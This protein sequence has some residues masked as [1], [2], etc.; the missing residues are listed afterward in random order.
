MADAGIL[1]AQDRVAALY[2]AHREAIYRFLLT[3]GLEPATAQELA[4]DAFVHL[5]VSLSNGAMIESE[6][7]W[8]YSVAAKRAVDHWRREGRRISAP[9]DDVPEI[10]RS[11]KSNE[12]TPEAAVI[13]K[14]RTRRVAVALAHLPETQRAAVCLRMQGLRYRAIATALDVS[15]ST[16]SELLAGAI[17]RLRSAANE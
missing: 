13:E 6:R 7:A 12:P 10:A 15:L 16:V 9:L 17:E 4:Q 11:L 3:R 14:Q 8:L 5:F 2:E 1:T